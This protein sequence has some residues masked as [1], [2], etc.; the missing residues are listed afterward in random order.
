MK[1]ALD[2]KGEAIRNKIRA[3]ND[4]EMMDFLT[5]LYF[6]ASGGILLIEFLEKKGVIDAKEYKEYAKEQLKKME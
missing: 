5:E 4:E 2:E 3:M 1:S 6:R